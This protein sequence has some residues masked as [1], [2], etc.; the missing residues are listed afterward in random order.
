MAVW[1]Y[2]GVIKLMEESIQPL[3]VPSILENEAIP[4][5]TNNK[6]TMN[7]RKSSSS[8]DSPDEPK[9]A[10]DLLLK[11]LTNFYTTLAA[12]GTDPELVTQ[13]FRQLFYFIC[14]GALNNLLLRKDMCHWSK[15]MQIRYN[16]S[17]LEQWTRDMKLPELCNTDALSPIIQAAQLLQA[18][19]T[20]DD[21]DSIC[22]MCNKLTLPQVILLLLILPK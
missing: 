6:P 9:K 4:G 10:L 3:V 5:L 1:I 12:F 22:E 16:L 15:G 7:G 19:K 14:A 13:V 8:E 2:N 20:D 17:H 21:I 11:E 18:R